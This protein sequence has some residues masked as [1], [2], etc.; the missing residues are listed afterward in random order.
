MNKKLILAIFSCILIVCTLISGCSSSKSVAP[1][2]TSAAKELTAASFLP[3]NGDGSFGIRLFAEKVGY[4]STG[5]LFIGLKGPESIPGQDQPAAVRTGVVDIASVYVQYLETEVPG[6]GIMM[7]SEYSPAELRANGGLAYINELLAPKGFYA[8]GISSPSDAQEQGIFI[9]NKDI[10]KL[11]DLK[12]L[13]VGCAG[14]AHSGFRAGLGMLPV[15]ID[16]ADFY[17]SM[18]RG[19]VDGTLQ[20]VPG[21]IEFGLLG[22]TKVYLDEMFAS[23]GALFIMKL[24]TWNNLSKA[25]KDILTK[26]AAET[27]TEGCTYWNGVEQQVKDAVINAGGKV[28]KFSAEESAEFHRI[29][30]VEC[31]KEDVASYPKEYAGWQ[32]YLFK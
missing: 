24:D 16:F 4:Y 25:D 28:V 3:L 2:T 29:Y 1:T 11:A 6:M 5:K 10:S 19:A 27:E 8:L 32:K 23:P 13:T 21:P 26:A 12:G 17:T 14:G 20:G 30:K 7:R 31:A 9:F 22:V 18:E 15:T